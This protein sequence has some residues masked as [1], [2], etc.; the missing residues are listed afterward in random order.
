M[1]EIDT[2][3]LDPRRK[4]LIYRGWYR[5]T[6]ENDFLIGNFVKEKI[7]DLTEDQL[8]R[9][10]SLI[11]DIDEQR[12]FRWVIGTEEIDPE[13]DTDVYRMIV[14]FNHELVSNA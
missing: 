4:K 2:S 7:A 5:G 1:S 3:T 6:K 13:Y 12:L 10:E 9:F 11:H 8:D 14:D